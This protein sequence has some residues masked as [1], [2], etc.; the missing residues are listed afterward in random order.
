[1]AINFDDTQPKS[2]I[3]RRQHA[4]S[5][6]KTKERQENEF[7]PENM[8]EDDSV[9]AKRVRVRLF[10]IWLR[11]IVV[12]ILLAASLAG[13]LMV[14]Y[15]IIGEGNPSDALEKSTWQHIYD[16]VMTNQR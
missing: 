7:T 8:E 16:I 13:G 12:G 1:M 6:A 11:V 5:H 2:R 10:P 15:G 9:K 4:Q 14:G 3:E